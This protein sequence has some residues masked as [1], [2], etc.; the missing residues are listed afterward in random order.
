[1]RPKRGY[2]GGKIGSLTCIIVE[3]KR[4]FKTRGNMDVNSMCM[5]GGIVVV[6]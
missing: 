1:M 3:G 5:L 6:T 4:G 2:S